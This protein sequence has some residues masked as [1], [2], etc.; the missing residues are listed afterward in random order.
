MSIHILGYGSLMHI[1]SLHRT[2]PWVEAKDLRPVRVKGYK[3]LFNLASMRS[4]VAGDPKGQKVGVLNVEQSTEEELGGIALPIR[5]EDLSALNQREF[6]YRRE[7]GIEAYDFFSGEKC[8]KIAL[9]T[10]YTASELAKVNRRYYVQRVRT[11]GIDST[12][13]PSILPDELY[14]SLCLQG[15]FSWG[16]VFGWHF[17][18]TTYLG[19][20]VTPLH[21]YLTTDEVAYRLNQ[22]LRTY[23]Q[24]R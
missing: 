12:L 5:K 24:N 9:Y 3:R 4:F 21:R 18:Q 23:I 14:L 2:V 16:E 11:K 15:A 17:M 22:D 7:E 8:E 20:G 10:A 6:L 19:D 13:Q 1:D